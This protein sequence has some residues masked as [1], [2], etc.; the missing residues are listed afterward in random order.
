[1]RLHLTRKRILCVVLGGICFW[2][3]TSLIEIVTRHELN[4]ATAT[5]LPPALL[6]LTYIGLRTRLG[7]KRSGLWMLAGVYV[8]GPIFMMAA[9]TPLRGGFHISFGSVRDW[10]YLGLMCVVP[11]FTLVLAGYD[12]TLFGVL[13]ATL[14][15]PLLQWW[16]DKRG[17]RL[18]TI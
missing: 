11:P 5:L 18:A 17:A 4:L 7:V 14:L 10:L 6:V 9:W 3:P 16:T 1:M 8:L 13:L 12:G 2:T 15:M